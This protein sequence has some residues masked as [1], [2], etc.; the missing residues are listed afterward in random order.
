[1]EEILTYR[2]WKVQ[3]REDK[4]LE[5]GFGKARHVCVGAA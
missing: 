4:H 1:M 2:A 3:E 5:P